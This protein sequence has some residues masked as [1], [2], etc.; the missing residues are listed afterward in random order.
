MQ[1]LRNI[2]ARCS[3]TVWLLALG[4]L[5][6]MTTLWMAIPFMSLFVKNAGGSDVTVGLVLA[7]NPVAQLLGNLVGGQWSD[8]RGRRPVILF[9]MG[10]RVFVF[11]GF[12]FSHTVW[13]LAALWFGNGLVNALF[14][15]AYTAAIADATPLDRRTEAFSLSRVAS[16]LG[17][18]LGPLLG[19]VLGVGAQQLI[20]TL[21]AISSAIVGAAF[22]FWLPE[23]YA[24]DR[25]PPPAGGRLRQTFESWAT[26]FADRALLVFVAGGVLSQIAYGQIHSSLVLHLAAWLPDYETVYGLVWT[27]NGILVVLLQIPITAVFKR[28]PM[29]AASVAGC[30][31]FAAGYLLFAWAGTGLQV[32]AA[33]VVWTLGE[34]ILAVPNTTYVTD[35][36][37]GSLRA[38]YVGAA[39]LDRALGG[40][41]APVIGTAVLQAFGGRWAMTGAG[42]LVLGAGGLYAMAE[43]ERTRRLALEH[44]TV[45]K[46]HTS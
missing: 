4:R 25:V 15:P 45:L 14:N 6:D 41:V 29:M 31:T 34:I 39:A 40:V 43:R 23:T 5:V 24:I 27:L 16:N 35:I 46:Q 3:P 13:Q 38:R 28:M 20:F 42:I 26:I 33:T 12:A 7:L 36:A 44:D 2:Y 17:V 9:A 1:Y 22:Y 18:G 19:S 11:L 30:G 37:P 10:L 32:H 21:A 8:R